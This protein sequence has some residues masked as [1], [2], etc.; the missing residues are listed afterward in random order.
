MNRFFF[1][2]IPRNEICPAASV[3]HFSTSRGMVLALADHRHLHTRIHLTFH[4]RAPKKWGNILEN[5]A[6]SLEA[7]ELSM[8][9]WSFYRWNHHHALGV[10]RQ[11]LV[12]RRPQPCISPP[13]QRER[14]TIRAMGTPFQ[15]PGTICGTATSKVL[16]LWI[17]V[18]WLSSTSQHAQLSP[19]GDDVNTSA[20][21][22]PDF[23]LRSDTD[24]R[25]EPLPAPVGAADRG[26]L[27]TTTPGFKFARPATIE[28]SWANPS[29]P[30]G[31]PSAAAIITGS[32]LLP[33]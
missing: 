28:F 21:H 4:L 12:D 31:R 9:R 30:F 8:R 14:G 11:I 26:G 6:P 23:R 20:D 2:M 5:P 10:Q 32:T 33:L 7:S 1:L 27:L 24:R 19:P 25:A 22:R 3:I 17:I 15:E 18:T 16:F 13:S 29:V